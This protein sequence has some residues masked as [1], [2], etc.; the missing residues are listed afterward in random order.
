MDLSD[1]LNDADG[2]VRLTGQRISLMHVVDGYSFLAL[3]AHYSETWE[4]QNRTVY[5][6]YD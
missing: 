3:V 6:P 2:E 4:W 1:F 5:V